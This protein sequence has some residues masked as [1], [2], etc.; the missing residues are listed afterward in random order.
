MKNTSKKKNLK[1][2]I[3]GV[4]AT[5]L[6]LGVAG[7]I[8]FVPVTYQVNKDYILANPD[9]NVQVINKNGYT[10]LA[11]VDNLGQ[12][13]NEDFKIMGVTDFHLDSYKKC[14][15][16]TLNTF[17]RNVVA[18]KPDLIVMVGDNITS[19]F[20]YRRAIQLANIMEELGVYWTLVLG[21]HEGIEFSLSREDQIKLFSE[22]DHCLV[23]AGTKYTKSGE[24]VYGNGNHAI[25]L[26]NKDGIAYETLFFID[27]GSEMTSEDVA[28]KG[29]DSS[30]T[31]YDYVKQ[32]QIDWYKET[33]LDIKEK[34]GVLTESIIF[35]H[36]ALPEYDIAYKELGGDVNVDVEQTINSNLTQLLYGKMREGVCCPNYNSGL[37]ATMKELNSTK[38]FV[39]GHD[40]VND[41]AIRYQGITL[42]YNLKSGYSSYQMVSKLKDRNADLLEG[43][44]MYTVDPDMN[45]LLKALNG[46]NVTFE[47]KTNADIYPTEQDSIRQL[48]KLDSKHQAQ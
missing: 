30:K 19:N 2:T 37:F 35:D 7:A 42:M 36:I 1:K 10:S 22:Y 15:A 11:K 38:L 40:H 8:A 45:I 5:C 46:S 28:A 20:N 27:G 21:N 33:V 18:E 14:G 25:N 9:Y 31:Q 48:V 43:Y 24:E 4:V 39:C 44:T 26:L 41:F 23:E 29:L 34:E 6:V 3:I 13:T 32:S 47:H 16:Y 17:I 12:F